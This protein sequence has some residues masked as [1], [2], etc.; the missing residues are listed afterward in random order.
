LVIALADNIVKNQKQ[1]NLQYLQILT[2]GN[3]I[4]H[5]NPKV[6]ELVKKLDKLLRKNPGDPKLLTDEILKISEEYLDE[7]LKQRG[8]VKVGVPKFPGTSRR[9]GMLIHTKY[10][11]ITGRKILRNF[12]NPQIS[13]QSTINI[14]I[15]TSTY[16]PSYIPTINSYTKPKVYQ[17]SFKLIHHFV[18][19]F[20][21]FIGWI[22]LT[23]LTLPFLSNNLPERHVFNLLAFPVI[24][25]SFVVYIL[26]TWGHQTLYYPMTK[27]IILQF[28]SWIVFLILLD[29]IFFKLLFTLFNNIF[30]PNVSSVLAVVI[31]AAY[32]AILRAFIAYG[33]GG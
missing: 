14:N 27:R 20:L 16:N 7:I 33:L 26:N 13:R 22:I 10:K 30:I 6:R 28:I 3:T 11:K 19:Q 24:S 12:Q 1:F 2:Q 17:Y 15:Q 18:E 5:P 32:T 25:A 23:F 4:D 21:T 9:K 29:S 8:T 31:L